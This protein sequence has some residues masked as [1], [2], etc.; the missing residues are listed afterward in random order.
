MLKTHKI[1]LNP[2]N[3][4]RRWFTQQG[5]YARFAYNHALADFKYV[6][7]GNS[8]LMIFNNY[9]TRTVYILLLTLLLSGCGLSKLSNIQKEGDLQV[10]ETTLEKNLKT[11]ERLAKLGNKSLVVKTS[12]AFSSY[13]GFLEDRMEEAEIAGDTETADEMRNNAIEHYAR[14]EMYAFKAL[15]KSD[16]TFKNARAANPDTFAKA[17]QKVK[18][19]DVE[20]LFWAAYS[21]GRGISLQK[22][23]PMQVIDLERVEQMMKR[24]LELDEAFYFGSAHLFYAVY[25]GDRSPAIGGDPEKAKSHIDRVDEINNGRFL[26]SKFYLAKYYAYPKQDV[27]LFKKTLQEVLDAPPD[28]HPGENAATSLAKARSERLLSQA[29]TLFDLEEEEI[30]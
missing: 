16:K 13:G 6:R 14:S 12:R 25:Y 26:M 17:V 15:A 9:Y 19:K 7:G 23:D 1:A 30:E 29:D 18:K 20:P 5:G 10:V 27:A 2:N 8:I 11:L 21:V 22:H 3:I 28:I 4:Q 24:V